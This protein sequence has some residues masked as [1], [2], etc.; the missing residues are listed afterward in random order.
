MVRPVARPLRAEL[1]H[2]LTPHLAS[3]DMRKALS[4]D[5]DKKSVI[6]H[7]PLQVQPGD[8]DPT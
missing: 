6:P 4:R 3:S 1:L 2:A 5:V 7:K 8:V